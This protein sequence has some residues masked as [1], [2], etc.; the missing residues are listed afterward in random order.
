MELRQFVKQAVIDIIGGIAD[1]R[2]EVSDCTA[3]Q[4]SGTQAASEYGHIDFE[5]TVVASQ[6]GG[7]SG[8][9]SIPLPFLSASAKKS[10]EK[11]DSQVQ[12]IRFRVPVDF[13]VVDPRARLDG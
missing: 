9:I 5:M 2:H 1:A 12:F 11:D 3:N 8:G 10:S 13:P 4:R 6:T 7:I